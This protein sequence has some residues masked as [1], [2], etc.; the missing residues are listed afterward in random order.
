MWNLRT[1]FLVVVTGIT[2]LEC[3][4][5]AAP[6]AE[7]LTFEKLIS[8]TRTTLRDS[9]ELPM[10]MRVSL[11]ASDTSGR[12]RK[13]KTDSYEYD[14]HGFN[15]KSSHVSARLRGGRGTMNAARNSSLFFVG[16]A[17]AGLIWI[18]KPAI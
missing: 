15:P 12:V 16:P 14:F 13:Q 11:V 4:T 10:V 18:L 8:A 17:R 6:P 5:T 2:G 9:A 1:I 3:Q 7:K